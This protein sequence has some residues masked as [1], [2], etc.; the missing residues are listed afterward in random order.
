MRNEERTDSLF[1]LLAA[2][3]TKS[4]QAEELVNK[5][6]RRRISPSFAA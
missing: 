6:S 5:Q 4:N 1:R 3:A 2:N